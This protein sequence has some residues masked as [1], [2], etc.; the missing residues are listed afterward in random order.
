MLDSAKVLKEVGACPKGTGSW[1]K[2]TGVT[3]KVKVDAV[4]VKLH[5]FPALKALRLAGVTP[6]LPFVS[7]R[8][9]VARYC[10]EAALTNKA[11]LIL[12]KLLTGVRDAF[13]TACRAPSKLN[14]IFPECS[15]SSKGIVLSQWNVNCSYNLRQCSTSVSKMNNLV[16]LSRTRDMPLVV[17]D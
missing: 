13:P 4:S 8:L 14:S 10:S 16:A 5:P 2:V 1:V 15:L 11:Q 9:D 7:T 17:E 12:A 6:K 3:S